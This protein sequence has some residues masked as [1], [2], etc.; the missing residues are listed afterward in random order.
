MTI[1]GRGDILARFQ[2]EEIAGKFGSRFTSVH[3]LYH[4]GNTLQSVKTKVLA[5]AT[6][7]NLKFPTLAEAT[8]PLRSTVD[9]RLLSSTTSD[10]SLLD[11]VLDMVLIECVNWDKTVEGMI[12]DAITVAGDA[13]TNVLNFGPGNGSVFQPQKPPHRNISLVD[14]SHASGATTVIT[15]PK[16]ARPQCENGIAIVGMGVNMPGATDAVGLWKILEEGLNTV[17]EVRISISRVISGDSNPL[18]TIIHQI[19]SSRFNISNYYNTSSST[20]KPVRSIGTKFGNFLENPAAF[21]N[22]FFNISP[23]EAKSLDPQQRVLLQTAYTAIENAGYV[24]D[25]TDTFARESFGCYVGVATGD[26]AENLR[27]DI[28]VYYSTGNLRAFLSGRISYTLKLGGPSLVV[29][30][31]CSS[32]LVAIYQACRALEAG[33]CNAAVAGGV[34][35]ITSPDVSPPPGT[36]TTQVGSCF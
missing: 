33:D 22:A 1:S 32:S 12:A 8:I 18:T 24:A 11:L 15:D 30:T 17:S 9:G 4:G 28:D 31:A 25:T 35:V 34:N 23:R 5:N 19:P 10:K 27:D 16:F 29:D 13:Q 21:D 26:Y 36:P 2:I 6:R 3:T 20:N 7:R 14:L